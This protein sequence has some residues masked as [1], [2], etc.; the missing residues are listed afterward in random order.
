MRKHRKKL[1]FEKAELPKGIELK[2]EDF[3][4]GPW[5]RKATGDFDDL[6]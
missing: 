5:N 1:S 2:Q 4:F 6:I 3:D